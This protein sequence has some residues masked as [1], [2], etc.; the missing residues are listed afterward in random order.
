MTNKIF[1]PLEAF[2]SMIIVFCIFYSKRY[3]PYSEKNMNFI[4]FMMKKRQGISVPY[5]PHL[6][7]FAL[8]AAVAVGL[9]A[10]I[11]VS[12]HFYVERK[13]YQQ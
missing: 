10:V 1:G 3:P 12:T 6:L 9:T 13:A 8:G 11:T 7:M 2:I 5:L 4:K